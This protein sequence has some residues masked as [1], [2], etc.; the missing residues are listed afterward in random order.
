MLWR[1]LE[2]FSSEERVAFIAFA[3][4]R[5]GLPPPGNEWE[6]KISITFC[7]RDGWIR[8]DSLASAGTCASAITIPFYSSEEKMAAS[9]RLTFEYGMTI[10]D[11]PMDYA[12][13]ERNG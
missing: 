6:S 9:L 3:S 7:D 10:S 1:V 8:K 4:G 5:G 13:V 12:E 11:G 2:S